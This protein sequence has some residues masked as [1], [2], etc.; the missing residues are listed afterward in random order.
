MI[1]GV[2]SDDNDLNNSRKNDKRNA[3]DV[4]KRVQEL[5]HTMNKH[6]AASLFNQK[7]DANHPLHSEV[8]SEYTTLGMIDLKFKIGDKY[9]TTDEIA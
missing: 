7:L 5:L 2:D 1:R 9:T 6:E 8:K 4:Y 3:T